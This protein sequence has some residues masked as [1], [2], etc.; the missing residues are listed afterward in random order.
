MVRPVLVGELGLRV[1]VATR[2][3][4]RLPAVLSPTALLML[5]LLTE[6]PDHIVKGL[7]DVDAILGRCLHKL[8]PQLLGQRLPFLCRDRPLDRLVTLVADEHH[9]HGEWRTARRGHGGPQVA[10]TGRG[11]RAGRLLDHLDLVVEFGDAGEGGARG[12]AVHEDKPL[13]VSNPL[14]AQRGVFLLA[15]RVQHLEHA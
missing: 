14:I 4:A 12:D 7:L 15:R 10:R 11:A 8:T 1:A 6:H 13:A 5:S 2:S 9:G 3:E